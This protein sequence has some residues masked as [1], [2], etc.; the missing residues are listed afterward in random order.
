MYGAESSIMKLTT[1]HVL[2]LT[3]TLALT[4]CKKPFLYGNDSCGAGQTAYVT[5]G[6]KAAICLP[7]NQVAYMMCTR[8]LSLVEH[9]SEYST[10]TE[11]QV[12]LGYAGAT[13][14]PSVA[15]NLSEGIRQKWAAEG[16]LEEARAQALRTCERFLAVPQK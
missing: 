9:N 13:V 12:T 1:P 16:K 10:S 15:T 7:Q 4:A 3:L 6:E 11:A 8:E 14:A 2:F 5:V